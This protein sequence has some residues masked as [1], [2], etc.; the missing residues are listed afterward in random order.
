M[1]IFASLKLPF[2]QMNTIDA[3]IAQFPPD[4]QEKLLKIRE[5]IHQIAPEVKEAISY[6]M[7]AFSI[8]GKP[9]VYFAVFKGHI[10]FY[11]T[12]EGI[13]KFKDELATYTHGKGSVRFPI[14]KPVPYELIA[15]IVAFKKEMAY[16]V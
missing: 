11:P 7:P 9:L 15:K 3:Y 2:I 1:I 13:A 12:A 14:N 16:N 8:D 6:R 5:L 4:V 10:G